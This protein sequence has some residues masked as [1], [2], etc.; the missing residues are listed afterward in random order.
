MFSV[1]EFRWGVLISSIQSK[2]RRRKQN[3]L[4]D[5][6]LERIAI[7]L[8]FQFRP[9]VEKTA[10]FK[11]FGLCVCV[12]GVKAFGALFLGELFHW[13]KATC[14]AVAINKWREDW[15]KWKRNNRRWEINSCYKYLWTNI[16]KL[17]LIN[18][19]FC[20]FCNYL[21]LKLYQLLVFFE[22]WLE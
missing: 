22:H 5:C 3:V 11:F 4:T 2:R 18:N 8:V 17:C 19:L 14:W 16:T 20:D 21:M 12:F 9:P 13:I 10:W 6:I 7:S 1:S 15:M